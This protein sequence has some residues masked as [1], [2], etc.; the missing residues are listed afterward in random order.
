ML[1]V[2]WKICGLELVGH[3]LLC[4]TLLCVW[5]LYYYYYWCVAFLAKAC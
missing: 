1:V 2:S 5:A 4:G 3:A